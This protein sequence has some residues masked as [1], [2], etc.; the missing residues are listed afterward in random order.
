[1]ATNKKI[2]MGAVAVLLLVGLTALSAGGCGQPWSTEVGCA[3]PIDVAVPD[4]YLCWQFANC[5][6]DSKFKDISMKCDMQGTCTCL[7]NT[8]ASSPPAR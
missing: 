8:T 3:D 1:M 6:A 2:T 5:G 7:M 4:P